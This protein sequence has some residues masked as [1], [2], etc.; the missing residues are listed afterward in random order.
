MIS[1]PERGADGALRFVDRESVTTEDVLAMLAEFSSPTT[2][3]DHA[4]TESHGLIHDPPGER[5]RHLGEPL[6]P[7]GCLP[8]GGGVRIKVFACAIHARCQIGH[9]LDDVHS[10]DGCDDQTSRVTP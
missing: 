1:F 2:D 9:K 8:C 7:I 10:C 6:E 3:G 5:C 4:T